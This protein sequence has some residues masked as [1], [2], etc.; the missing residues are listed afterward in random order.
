MEGLAGRVAVVTG[1][2]T[3][4]GRAIA[5]QLA[6]LGVKIILNGRDVSKGRTVQSELQHVGGSAHFVAGDVRSRVDMSHLVDEA[7]SCYG[8]I[9]YLVSS[10]G[11][12]PSG[13]DRPEGQFY[14]PFQDLD[15]EDVGA[16]VGGI[17]QGK[18]MPVHAVVPHMI[19]RKSGS[20]LFITSEGGRYPTP[21][22]TAIA[23]QAAG[24]IMATKV[25]A[26]ELAHYQI[27]VNCIALSVIEGTKVAE[28]A[29]H[30]SSADERLRR[31]AKV[32]ERAPFG[33]AQGSDIA[34]VAAFLLSDSAHFITGATLSPTGGLTYS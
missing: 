14:A 4:I 15:I 27:R 22:Q 16:F 30:A 5:F 2:N 11:G 34:S 13:R 20:I 7:L 8:C 12:W 31:Y 18:L 21:G 29:Q 10:A 6:A 1:S 17:T 33:L 26:K 28:E 3:G 25:I 23:A 24:L 19:A 32:R 9:D